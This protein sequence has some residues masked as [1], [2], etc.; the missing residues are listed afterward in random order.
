[1]KVGDDLTVNVLGRD[2]TAKISNLRT[3]DWQSLGINFV[4]VF[5]PTTFAG[6]PPIPTSHAVGG[7][8]QT[9]PPTPAHQGRRRRL[10]DGDQRAGARGARLRSARS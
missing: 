10:P 1:V 8:I 3:V 6:A 7:A 4:L 9:L 5:S 2:I